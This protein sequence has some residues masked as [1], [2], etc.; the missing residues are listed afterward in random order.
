MV[1]LV[2]GCLL[3]CAFVAPDGWNLHDALFA[4]VDQSRDARCLW[5]LGSSAFTKFAGN[6]DPLC[7]HLVLLDC[8]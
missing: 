3:V 5:S 8:A 2:G 1:R 4:V 6:Q 7:Y